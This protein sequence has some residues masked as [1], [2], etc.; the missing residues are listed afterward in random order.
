MEIR[1]ITVRVL[2]AL[3]VPFVFLGLIDP[4]EGGL[5]LAVA[6]L[7]YVAAFALSK[8]RPPKLLWI[9]FAVSL[10]VGASTLG[11]AIANLEF[12]QR[13]EGLPGPIIFGLWGYRLAVAV[14]LAG[15][16]KTLIGSFRTK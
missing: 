3:A 13:P 16:I 8:Q 14:T 10:V 7:I 9:P 5:A 15:A 1:K 6:L 4:L 12:S 11:L 2:F